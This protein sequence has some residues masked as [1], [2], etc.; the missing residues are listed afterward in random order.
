MGEES[1]RRESQQAMGEFG[2]LDTGHFLI[3]P[4]VAG[5]DLGAP[6]VWSSQGV[7]LK[8]LY[9]VCLSL[10]DSKIPPEWYMPV[11]CGELKWYSKTHCYKCI[12]GYWVCVLVRV[13]KLA[14]SVN[15]FSRAG[16]RIKK[17]K[18]TIRQPCNMIPQP[19]LRLRQAYFY[20]TLIT[21]KIIRSALG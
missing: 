5:E 11:I 13:T 20:T 1:C 7:F 14:W 3:G 6:S 18:K 4:G 17:E 21:C 9:V 16:V 2:W 19:V 12:C 8:K 10:E 15:R